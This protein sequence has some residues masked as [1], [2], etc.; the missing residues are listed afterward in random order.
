MNCCIYIL[1]VIHRYIILP[2]VR[3]YSFFNRKLFIAKYCT[4][5]VH[6]EHSEK[7]EVNISDDDIDV[8]NNEVFTI[9]YNTMDKYIQSDNAYKISKFMSNQL[10][11]SLNRYMNVYINNDAKSIGLRKRI[12]DQNLARNQ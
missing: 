10:T 7:F 6:N 8:V 5:D 12:N 1:S 2:C 3:I 4:R 9:L 11:N